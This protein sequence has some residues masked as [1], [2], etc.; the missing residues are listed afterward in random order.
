MSMNNAGPELCTTLH[1]FVCKSHVMCLCTSPPVHSIPYTVSS[2][3]ISATLSCFACNC[4]LQV[5][6]LASIWKNRGISHKAYSGVKLF[7]VPQKSVT[8]Q[9]NNDQLTCCTIARCHTDRKTMW[10][11]TAICLSFDLSEWAEHIMLSNQ[12]ITCSTTV[13][14]ILKQTHKEMRAPSWR[15]FPGRHE[16][17]WKDVLGNYTS[18]TAHWDAL[19]SYD[20]EWRITEREHKFNPGALWQHSKVIS[21][22]AKNFRLG[23]NQSK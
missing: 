4:S 11:A 1:L 7:L 12:Y 18:S 5:R 16:L 23:S 17:W 22:P 10:S 9:A 8:T 2:S 21:P 13:W 3:S 6:Y 15:L 14:F 19:C 20:C